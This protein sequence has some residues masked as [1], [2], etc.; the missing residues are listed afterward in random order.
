MKNYLEK[1]I[2][3]VE[4]SADLATASRTAE[5]IEQ[6]KEILNSAKFIEQKGIRSLVDKDARVGYKSKTDSF[7]GYKVEFAMIP[8]ERII[9]A[10]N[11]QDGA[12]VDGTVKAYIPVSQSVYKIDDTKFNYNKDSDQWICE[13]GHSTTSK[14]KNRDSYYY[15][16]EKDACMSYTKKLECLYINKKR[17]VLQITMNTVSLQR[18]KDF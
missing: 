4:K 12:Y 5:A 9:T 10:V 17:K 7:Y 18:Q 16:F 1:V 14:K 6:A 11:V 3:D 8:E 15:Y 2:E 13:M